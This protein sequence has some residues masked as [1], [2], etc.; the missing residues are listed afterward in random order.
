[1][2]YKQKNENWP[3]SSIKKNVIAGYIP[4]AQIKG[5]TVLKEKSLFTFSRKMEMKQCSVYLGFVQRHVITVPMEDFP[6]RVLS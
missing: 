6:L 4:V 1:M 5:K 3:D 2:D